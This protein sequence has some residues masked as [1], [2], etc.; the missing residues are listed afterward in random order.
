MEAETVVA[1]PA[2]GESR[3]SWTSHETP[4]AYERRPCPGAPWTRLDEAALAEYLVGRAADDSEGPGPLATAFAALAR[5]E[6]FTVRRDSAIQPTIAG[7][8]LF[9]VHPE[10]LH[11]AW[12]VT[13]MR[14]VGTEAPVL[15]VDRL[16]TEGPAPQA[17]QEVEAFLRRHLGGAE[18]QASG[19]PLAAAKEAIA[20]A[21][22][23]RD[24]AAP[25][26]V[27][28]RLYDDRLEVENPG[29]LLPGST[30]EG[31][32]A[33]GESCARNPI[34]AGALRRMGFMA[35]AGRGLSLIHQEM[36]RLDAPPPELEA[37]RQHFQV[38]LR[39]LGAGRG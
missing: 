13:A 12:R 9:G 19:L 26:P 18:G 23:H 3:Q 38:T 1:E 29:G 4:G 31:V 5:Q 16:D 20:N 17:I 32:L 36:A 8:A 33:D 7:Y 15:V 2:A 28:V 35:P 11:P 25:S 6:K 39:A 34:I 37:D 21:V 22:A 30:L 10:A 14:L 27:S 24:Y